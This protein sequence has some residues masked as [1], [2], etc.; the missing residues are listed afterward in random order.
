M[1]YYQCPDCGEYGSIVSEETEVHH[2]N[3]FPDENGHKMYDGYS[4]VVHG[5]IDNIV[6]TGCYAYFREDDLEQ[7]IVEEEE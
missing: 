7:M 5:Q 4:E 2:Y 1:R 6:C 3:I